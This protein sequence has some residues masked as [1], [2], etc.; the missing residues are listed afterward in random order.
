[1]VD[2]APMD[3]K[4]D[5][6]PDYN[7]ENQEDE[8]SEEENDVPDLT[9][10]GESEDFVFEMIEKEESEEEMDPVYEVYDPIVQDMFVL[11]EQG[12][13]GYVTSSENGCL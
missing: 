2:E 7:P 4:Q 3:P 9:S 13:D 6:D 5:E 10:S 11:E 1:M 8:P 12:E